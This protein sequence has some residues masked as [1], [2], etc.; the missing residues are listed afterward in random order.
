MNQVMFSCGRKILIAGM[1]CVSA[2][3][4][5]TSAIAE[6]SVSQLVKASTPIR[7]ATAWQ[8]NA[9]VQS[10]FTR[11]AGG[12]DL[13]THMQNA[14]KIVPGMLGVLSFD[15]DTEDAEA[16]IPKAIA[17]FGEAGSWRWMVSGGGAFDYHRDGEHYDLTWT[18]TYF[19]EDYFSINFGLGGYYFDQPADTPGDAVGGNLTLLF[20]WHFYVQDTWSLYADAGAGLLI[21]SEEIPE[22]GSNF[23]FTPQIGFGFST[24]VGQ[25]NAR[26]LIGVKWHHISNGSTY[27]SDNNP[28]RDAYKGYIGLSFPFE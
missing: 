19:L 14:D 24:N 23:N 4:G 3:M 18:A 1:L 26:L 15:D 8:S 27:G 10:N 12:F 20:R 28:G 16:E 22:G 7:Q 21:V 13:A 5:S 11:Q 17:P 6:Q 25:D 9:P 2:F